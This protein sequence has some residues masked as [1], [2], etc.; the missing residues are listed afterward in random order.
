MRS[1]N[2]RRVNQTWS[3]RWVQLF[4]LIL[5]KM[6]LFNKVGV[7][8]FEFDRSI[9][10]NASFPAIDGKKGTIIQGKPQDGTTAQVTIMVD[11]DDFVDLA[12]GKANAPA[13][14]LNSLSFKF[15]QNTRFVIL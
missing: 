3:K 10:I 11:D 4:F 1:L 2:V 7:S 6:A 15:D 5:P 13:V 12:S 8:S 14:R 9:Y